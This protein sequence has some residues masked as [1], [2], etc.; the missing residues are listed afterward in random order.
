MLKTTSN[1]SLVKKKIL[2]GA[3]MPRTISSVFPTQQLAKRAEA[4]RVAK[5]HTLTCKVV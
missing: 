3:A 5:H 2:G 1:T 4:M